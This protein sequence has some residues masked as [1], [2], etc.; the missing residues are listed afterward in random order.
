MTE[1]Q[2]R[3]IEALFGPY[4]G[5]IDVPADIAEQA[6]ADGWARDPFAPP[7]EN[8]E[9]FSQEKHDKM[10]IAAEQAARK[11]RGEPEPDKPKT[12]TKETTTRQMTPES[13]TS[14]ASYKTRGPGRPPKSES[15]SE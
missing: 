12:K 11:L 8:P 15:E 1:K 3:R 10:L 7:P 9:P 13:E 2:I 6:I 4:R 14:G 5:I